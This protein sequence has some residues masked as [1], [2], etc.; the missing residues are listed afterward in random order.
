MAGR[1]WG[2]RTVLR[3]AHTLET[4]GPHAHVFDYDQAIR[5]A[6]YIWECMENVKPPWGS[7][8]ENA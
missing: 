5:L 2:G 4:A 8:K 6:T 3:Q 1:V 7:R